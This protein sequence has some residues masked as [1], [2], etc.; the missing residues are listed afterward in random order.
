MNADNLRRKS[1]E[2]RE[3][4]DDFPVTTHKEEVIL[5]EII[6]KKDLP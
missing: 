1:K 2:L 4:S 5:P 6:L 3:L